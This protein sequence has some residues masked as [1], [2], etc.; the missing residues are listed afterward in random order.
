MHRSFFHIPSRSTSVSA[1]VTASVAAAVDNFVTAGF[2]SFFGL[3][4]NTFVAVAESTRQS[5][6]NFRSAAAATVA[7]N[8]VADF[9]GRFFAD[10]FI[11]V[12]QSVDEGTHDF[13][14]ATAIVLIAK[15][16]NCIAT[17]FGIA[18][19][20][21]LVDQQGDHARITRAARLRDFLAFD[22]AAFSLATSVTAAILL[23]VRLEQIALE[24]TATVGFASGVAA[25]V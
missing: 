23:V 25:A 24:Q 17:I 4:T 8:L 9:V 21:R 5:G 15:F 2:E 14:V 10:T 13:R 16:V 11:S 19:R 3:V 6:H 12:V 20:L 1:S 22:F 18:S 7:A